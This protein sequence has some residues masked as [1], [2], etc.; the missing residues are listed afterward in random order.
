MVTVVAAS[1]SVPVFASVGLV[2]AV[3]L[4]SA[5]R[6][7]TQSPTARAEALVATWEVIVVF[8]V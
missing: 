7:L 3:G 4:S 8:D 6:T 5:V 2:E 1:V